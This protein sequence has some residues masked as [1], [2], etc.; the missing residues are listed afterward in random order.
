MNRRWSALALSATAV[1]AFAFTATEAAADPHPDREFTVVKTDPPAWPDE[2]TGF[3]GDGDKVP[4]YSYPNYDPKYEPQVRD[5]RYGVTPVQAASAAAKV[6]KSDAGETALQMGASAL[7]AAGLCFG[8]MW[9]V[10]RHHR[11]AT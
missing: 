1:G 9:L 7:G 2:G 8:G 5:A 6:S 4:E 10:R 3:P 11:P